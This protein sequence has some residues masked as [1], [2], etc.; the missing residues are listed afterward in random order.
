MPAAQQPST[1]QLQ[2]GYGTGVT[3]YG[4]T[5]GPGY[6]EE[7]TVP[8]D[9]DSFL[10]FS[11]ESGAGHL[12]GITTTGGAPA[13]ANQHTRGG[14]NGG[15]GNTGGVGS[16]AI[17]NGAVNANGSGG[18]GQTSQQARFE[19]YAKRLAPLMVLEQR[20]MRQLSFPEEDDDPTSSSYNDSSAPSNSLGPGRLQPSRT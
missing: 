5:S 1:S 19:K 7:Y 20:L 15:Y 8:Q 12:N 4:G 2:N 11:Y 14:G 13:F 17:A 16:V 10:S 9:I 6:Q 18:A 3:D